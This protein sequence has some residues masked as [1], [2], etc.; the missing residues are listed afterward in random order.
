MASQ[1]QQVMTPKNSQENIKAI[2]E[3]GSSD[4]DEN[5]EQ[6]IAKRLKTEPK[7]DLGDPENIYD[8]SD[9]EHNCIDRA[10][11]PPKI[12]PRV[13]S[14]AQRI[15]ESS[16]SSTGPDDDSSSD[17][18]DKRTRRS[19]TAS[20]YFSYRQA[21]K[22]GIPSIP[23]TITPAQAIGSTSKPQVAILQQKQPSAP[24]PGD[25]SSD[26]GSGSDDESESDRNPTPFSFPEASDEDEEGENDFEKQIGRASCRERVF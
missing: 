19:W 3:H 11:S 8:C 17:F 23:R 21:K 2:E 4:F 16:D 1:N 14:R 15:A 13:Q 9:A 10:V 6:R 7:D 22:Q 5:V 12:K 25:S 18:E 26:E 24:P 20:T